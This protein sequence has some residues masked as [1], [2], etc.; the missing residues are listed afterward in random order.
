LFHIPFNE[1][2]L[3]IRNLSPF[4]RR[5]T[6]VVFHFDVL[7]SS[8]SADLESRVGNTG[9]AAEFRCSQ[10]CYKGITSVPTKFYL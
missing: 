7:T 5:Q 1:Q 3:D 9:E 4:F 6:M 10:E 2:I 8:A